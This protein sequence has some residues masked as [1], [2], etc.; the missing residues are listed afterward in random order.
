[1]P[2]ATR[3]NRRV[4]QRLAVILLI[5]VTAFA[6]ALVGATKASAGAVTVTLSASTTS[7]IAGQPV[8][9]T[10]TVAGVDG[11]TPTGGTVSILDTTGR[12]W[13]SGPV[14]NGVATA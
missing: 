10:A 1:M 5:G 4:V 9:F 11:T 13:A 14:T 8:T 7:P 12:T 2:A 3:I 6:C